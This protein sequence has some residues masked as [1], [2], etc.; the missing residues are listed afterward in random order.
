MFRGRLGGGAEDVGEGVRYRLRVGLQ[1]S[2][3]RGQPDPL[4]LL[5]DGDHLRDR[6]RQRCRGVVSGQFGRQDAH[7]GCEFVGRA[8]QPEDERGGEPVR[9]LTCRVTSQPAQ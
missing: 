9:P 3:Q 2:Q 5:G 4:G 6:G 8:R 1:G 7:G